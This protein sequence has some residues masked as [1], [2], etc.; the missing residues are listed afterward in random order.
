MKETAIKNILILPHSPTTWI[1]FINDGE[2]HAVNEKFI[3]DLLSKIAP[4]HVYS[5]WERMSRSLG[6]YIDLEKNEFHNV[7]YDN[8]EILRDIK[9][10][11][12]NID[13]NEVL[14]TIKEK[15]DIIGQK[16]KEAISERFAKNNYYNR[17]KEDV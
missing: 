10:D 2:R 15:E 4:T 1:Y 11:H 12:R 9:R 16:E 3:T 5:I 13:F 7:N 8:E 17:R 14:K 6:F